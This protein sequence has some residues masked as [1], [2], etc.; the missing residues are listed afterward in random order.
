MSDP[1]TKEVV[2]RTSTR[3]E[4]EQS[5]GREI[6]DITEAAG[7]LGISRWSLYAAAG[8]QEIPHRRVGRRILFSRSA[9]VDWLRASPRRPERK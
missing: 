1:P 5:M 6:M 2:Q 7:F 4:P 3:L 8:R 9:M